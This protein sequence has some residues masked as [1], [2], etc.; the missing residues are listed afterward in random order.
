MGGKARSGVTAGKARSSWLVVVAIAIIAVTT[1]VLYA[2]W[3]SP[4]RTSLATYGAF[5]LP[6]VLAAGGWVISVY[7]AG[8]RSDVSAAS[9]PELEK[10]TD[11]LARSVDEQWSRAAGERGLE[12]QPIPVRWQRA[13]GP[14]AGP[15]LAAVTSSSFDPLPGLTATGERRLQMGRVS[16]LHEVYGG[17]GSGKLVIVGG[18]GSGKSGAGVLLIRAALHYRRI[19]SEQ[20]R[21]EVPVLVMFTLH[22]W[23]PNA[24]SAAD[25]LAERLWQ[26]YPVFGGKRGAGIARTML[27]ERRIAVILDGLDEIPKDLRPMALKA[28]SRQVDFRLVLLSRCDEMAAAAIQAILQGAAAIELQAIDADTAA[29]YLAS[30]QV[31]PPPRS[32]HKLISHL[33]QEPASPLA[34][35]LNNPLMLTLVRDIYRAKDVSAL[36]SLRDATGHRAS[37]QYIADHLLD[38]VLPAAYTQQPDKPLPYKRLT[39]ERALRRIATRMSQEGTRDLQWWHVPAWTYMTPRVIATCLEPGLVAGVVLGLLAGL[40]DGL[41]GLKD[42]FL[43]GLIAGLLPGLVMGPIFGRGYK[44]PKRI[45]TL[46]WRQLFSR[47]ALVVGFLF[48]L[49]A[50]ILSANWDWSQ[51]GHATPVIT[52]LVAGLAAGLWVALVA[53]M[54]RPGTDSTSP[55]SPIASWRSDRAVGF[56]AGLIAGL[57]T[58][59]WAGLAAG[60]ADGGDFVLGVETGLLFGVMVWLAVGLAY[61]QSWPSA[62]AFVQLA[63]SDRTPVR[64]MRFLEDARSR[65]VLRTVG[66][67]YQFRHARLQDRLAGRESATQQ[68]PGESRTTAGETEMPATGASPLTDV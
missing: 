18:P 62:L 38:Q 50:N 20:V 64:L 55:L 14:F 66:P 9:G 12:P 22:G 54:S 57:I 11:L 63:I 25:W 65:D 4:Q 7:R 24:Q 47:T 21:P 45:A 30:T 26:T 3:R 31:H 23:D 52:G 36:L 43:G 13:V 5:A 60:L 51:V 56:V 40:T 53:G 59:L 39:A 41:T 49:I 68:D 32:W 61:P 2:V 29:S 1:W 27:S 37:S 48:A 6:L 19:V 34:E 35:A 10:L 42:G 15:V 28:L 67:V 17:L 44:T 8:G 33:R 16:E 46:R 58:G